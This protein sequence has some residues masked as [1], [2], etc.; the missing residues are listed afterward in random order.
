MSQYFENDP[1]IVSKKINVN[2]DFMGQ[3]INF[4]SD[5]GIF[6]KNHVDKGTRA[7][8]EVLV[9]Y[10][11]DGQILDLGC[12]YGPI[13]LTLA[14]FNQNINVTLSDINKRAI[15]LVDENIKHLSL[16]GRCK[17]ILSN[18]Y[19]NIN[20]MF[21][22]I[23]INPPIRAGKKITYAMF[24][25]AYY[26]LKNLGALYIVIRKNQGAQSTFKYLESLFESV[27]LLKRNK[28]YWIIKAQKIIKE[29]ADE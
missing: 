13:G 29:P 21:D 20:Q 19:Q 5:N 7:L 26:H 10:Q 17:G 12:G 9:S 11:L 14:L 22:V 25:G 28:G 24:E 1:L 4:V 16:Q 8:L 3:N 2:F 6:A 23:V 15:E 18:I 27:T